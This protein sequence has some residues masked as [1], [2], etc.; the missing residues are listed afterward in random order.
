MTKS[1]LQVALPS[2]CPKCGAPSLPE[3]IHV[4]PGSNPLGFTYGCET[5]GHEY[6][7][8]T[9]HS[10]FPEEIEDKTPVS[11][12]TKRKPKADWGWD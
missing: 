7:L 12:M 5:C 4:K 8:A 10:F 2:K 1:P 11:V 3:D 6:D 9:I